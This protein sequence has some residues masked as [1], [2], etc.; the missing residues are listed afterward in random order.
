MVVF[1]REARHPFLDRLNKDDCVFHF[2]V[3]LII[4]ARIKYGS[5]CE[6]LKKAKTTKPHAN[7]FVI[8]SAVVGVGT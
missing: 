6:K 8:H 7:L 1:P 5:P 3:V 4:P 2:L